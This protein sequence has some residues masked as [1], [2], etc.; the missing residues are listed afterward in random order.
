MTVEDTWLRCVV[1]HVLAD[2]LRARSVEEASQMALGQGAVALGLIFHSDRGRQCIDGKVREILTAFDMK[3][4]MTSTGNCYGNA[5]AESFIAT[6]KKGHVFA[7]RFRTRRNSQ[8][9]L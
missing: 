7:L 1:G 8:N 9:D 4:N 3:Q 5:M 6:I 2:H